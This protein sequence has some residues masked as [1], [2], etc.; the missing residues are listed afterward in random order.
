MSN[1][2]KNLERRK[3]LLNDAPSYSKKR[4][5]SS[6]DDSESDKSDESAW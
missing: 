5:S 4:N 3:K 6:E 2:E 1:I